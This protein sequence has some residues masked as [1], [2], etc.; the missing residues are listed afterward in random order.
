[1]QQQEIKK[2]PRVVKEFGELYEKETIE[3]FSQYKLSNRPE[4]VNLQE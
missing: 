1:M 4:L 2:D 3:W